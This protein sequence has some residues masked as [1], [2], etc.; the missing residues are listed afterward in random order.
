MILTTNDSF[1][2]TQRLL[3]STPNVL[4]EGVL[5]IVDDSYWSQGL[6]LRCIIFNR[7][8]GNTLDPIPARKTIGCKCQQ[9]A[10]YVVSI[11]IYIYNY[12]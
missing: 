5:D 3:H 6:F 4:Y 10:N 7:I 12:I 8:I 2:I 9:K 1:L 11:Y